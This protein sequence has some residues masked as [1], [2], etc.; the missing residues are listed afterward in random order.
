MAP[1]LYGKRYFVMRDTI[2]AKQIMQSQSTK[3]L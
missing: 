3:L 2:D 1:P